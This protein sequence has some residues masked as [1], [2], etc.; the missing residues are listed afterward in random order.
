MEV[1]NGYV[2]KSCC[3]VALA[4]KGVDPAHPK[5]DPANPAFDPKVAAADKA[6]AGGVVRPA[7]TFGGQLAAVNA[8][9]SVVDPT[10][11][12]TSYSPGSVI[13]LSA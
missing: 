10:R 9:A 11:T 8:T 13:N 6:K 3:D 7:V 2:C 4:K 5:D 1:V 12:A